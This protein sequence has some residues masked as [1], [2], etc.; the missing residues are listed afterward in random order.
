MRDGL[1]RFVRPTRRVVRSLTRDRLFLRELSKHT[2]WELFRNALPSSSSSLIK[3]M[4]K[5]V[6]T[7]RIMSAMDIHFNDQIL[8]Y[9]YNAL[10]N[11]EYFIAFMY[12]A[13]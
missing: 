7:A 10:N 13:N 1:N 4:L 3:F 11:F 8:K 9:R 6:R 12:S 5:E 2:S